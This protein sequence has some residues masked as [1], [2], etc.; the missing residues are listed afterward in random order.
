MGVLHTKVS[1]WLLDHLSPIFSF[2]VKTATIFL[3]LLPNFGGFG[4]DTPSVVDPE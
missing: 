2:L 3:Y 4:A 1:C